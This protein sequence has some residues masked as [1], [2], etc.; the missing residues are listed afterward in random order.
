MTYIASM[1]CTSLLYNVVDSPV[2]TVPVTKVDPDL[3]RL[4]DEWR[5]Q[6]AIGSPTFEGMLYKGDNAIYNVDRMSGLPVG[7]QVVGKKWEEEKVV[8]MMKVVDTALGKRGFGPGS[9]K[10]KA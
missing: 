5:N 4:T 2:G 9:W 10:A 8:E 7:V 6:A 3:D 1:A